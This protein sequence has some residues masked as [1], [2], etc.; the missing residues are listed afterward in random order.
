RRSCARLCRA[1][2][3]RSAT[4]VPTA[5]SRRPWRCR[6]RAPTC[7]QVP[8]RRCAFA[9]HHAVRSAAASCAAVCASSPLPRATPTL[10]AAAAPE[11]GGNG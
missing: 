7:S 2:T 4:P 8:S 1:G 6:L 3:W 11:E 5:A 9:P 10:T